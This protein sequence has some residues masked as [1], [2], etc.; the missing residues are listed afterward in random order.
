MGVFRQFLWSV[1]LSFVIQPKGWDP[2]K[3]P[4]T[5][6]KKA[7][8]SGKKAHT[9]GKKPAKAERKPTQVEKWKMGNETYSATLVI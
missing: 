2:R 5:H 6:G 8:T 9:S 4:H 7:Y 1:F 3:S